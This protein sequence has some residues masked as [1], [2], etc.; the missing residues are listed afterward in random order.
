MNE[1]Y[2]AIRNFTCKPV[3]MSFGNSYIEWKTEIGIQE[4]RTDL[5]R[6][7][8]SRKMRQLINQSKISR[9]LGTTNSN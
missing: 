5:S 6:N 7:K 1:K 9:E 8:L 3:Y 2:S 4:K